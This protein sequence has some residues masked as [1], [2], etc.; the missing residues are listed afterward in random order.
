MDGTGKIGGGA[1]GHGDQRTDKNTAPFFSGSGVL[2][3]VD[4]PFSLLS[5]CML[6]LREDTGTKRLVRSLLSG[7]NGFSSVVLS[8][9][10]AHSGLEK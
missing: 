5:F 1:S 10:K 6:L 9:Q 2:R 3:K 7:D 8:K 4:S